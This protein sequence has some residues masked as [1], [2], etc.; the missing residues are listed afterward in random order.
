M[1]AKSGFVTALRLLGKVLPGERLKT[2]V[3]LNL[4]MKPRDMLYHVVNDFYR[5]DHIYQVLGEVK[6]H[7]TGRFSVLEFGVA[8]GYSMSKILYAVRYMKMEDR[9]T[10]HGFDTFE[11]MPEA[12]DGMDTSLVDGDEWKP[13]QFRSSHDELNAYLGVRHQNYRLHRGLFAD[14]L[15]DELLETFRDDLPI[16]VWIDCDYYSSARSV[17]ERLIDYLPNG[18]VV[19]FD[20][21]EFNYGSRFT[22]EARLVHEV[23]HGE[24]GDNRELVLDRSLSRNS[25]RVYRFIDAESGPRYDRRF[26]A[27]SVGDVRRPTSGSPLP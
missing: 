27:V 22:G 19:Y 14:T 5:I 8:H 7:Y 3:Y 6:R 11:G 15:T 24:F 23:N 1:G 26:M 13:G 25:S 21:I 20:E 2:A 12:E 16:L 17:F 18:C 9:V 4:I 10:V